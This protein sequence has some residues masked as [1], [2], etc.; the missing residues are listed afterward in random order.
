MQNLHY[1]LLVKVL[2]GQVPPLPRTQTAIYEQ[3][4]KD[5]SPFY[6]GMSKSQTMLMYEQSIA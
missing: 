4:C 6:K 1:F 2:I 3:E 5:S